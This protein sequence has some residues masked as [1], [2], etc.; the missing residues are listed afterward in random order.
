MKQAFFILGAVA[1]LATTHCSAESPDTSASSPPGSSTSAS[2]G[3]PSAGST[4]PSMASVT[5]GQDLG[6]F[7]PYMGTKTYESGTPPPG[8]AYGR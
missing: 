6:M 1:L 8:K 7:N 5:G 2:T 4:T 3:T